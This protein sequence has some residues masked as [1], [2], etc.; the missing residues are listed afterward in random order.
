MH[1]PAENPSQLPFGW[2]IRV[3][4]PELEEAF[5]LVIADVPCSG[6]GVI[7]KKPEIRYKAKEEIR[8][9][10]EIQLA[11]LE[12]LSRYVFSDEIL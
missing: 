7:G 6:F 11:I 5:D 8:A 3:F 1:A 4:D 2:A 9:L 12:N 10:P